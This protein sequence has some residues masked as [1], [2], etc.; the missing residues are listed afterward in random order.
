[1]L[2]IISLF[3]AVIPVNLTSMLVLTTIFIDVS[4]NLPKTSYMKMIYVW[5]LVN[6]LLL[7]MVVL[8]HTY[9]DTLGVDEDKENINSGMDRK[10]AKNL[11]FFENLPFS[12]IL[13]LFSHLHLFIGQLVSNMQDLFKVIE[14][15]FFENL[16]ISS[17]LHYLSFYNFANFNIIHI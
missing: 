7:F 16:I 8:T 13:S 12:I 10:R 9:M 4:N 5:L 1:M 17:T 6:L 2:L 15:G 11:P 3:Q 14:I